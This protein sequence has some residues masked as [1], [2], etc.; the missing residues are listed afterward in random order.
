MTVK[1]SFSQ[2]LSIT[3]FTFQYKAIIF[4]LSHQMT[5]KLHLTDGRFV[6][7]VYV[8][9]STCVVITVPTP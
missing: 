9:Y 6:H 2:A 3:C 7:K 4:E 8:V 5:C 1:F